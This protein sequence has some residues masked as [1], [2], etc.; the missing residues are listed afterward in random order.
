[1]G[2][3]TG[4]PPFSFCFHPHRKAFH[5]SINRSGRDPLSSHHLQR[6]RDLLR[7]DV[8][9]RFVCPGIGRAEADPCELPHRRLH[10]EDGASLAPVGSLGLRIHRNLYGAGSGAGSA[11]H[12]RLRL[13]PAM[14]EKEL[15]RASVSQ[16]AVPLT[17]AKQRSFALETI[18]A[19]RKTNDP[20]G[21][22]GREVHGAGDGT[23]TREY[24]LG[25]LIPYPIFRDLNYPSD[26][27]VLKTNTVILANVLDEILEKRLVFQPTNNSTLKHESRQNGDFRHVISGAGDENRTR[28]R[29]LGSIGN[30]HYTTP[31][32]ANHYNSAAVHPTG[33]FNET[34]R[35]S[36]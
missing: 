3:R 28:V 31:A 14:G 10:H 15:A 6:Q 30:N 17:H 36:A 24:K 22:R 25:K 19:S 7:V 11:R 21:R 26:L 29:C 23:R 2:T 4:R 33:Q 35:V 1:M 18:S 32:L 12:H 8:R 16:R 5:V 20:A 13:P 27:A 9:P 34:P